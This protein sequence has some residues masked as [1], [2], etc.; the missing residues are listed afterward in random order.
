MANHEDTKDTKTKFNN[1]V[2]FN[3]SWFALLLILLIACYLRVVA[4]DT[5]PNGWRDDEVIETTV[6]AQLI[7]DGHYPLYFTQAA[8]Q[9]P[10]YHYIAALFIGA[11]GKSLFV[12]RLVS[13][14]LGLLSVAASYRLAKQFFG[15]LYALIVALLIAV[16]FWSLMWSRTKVRPIAELPL[17]LIGLSLLFKA[18]SHQPSTVSKKYI[19]LAGILLGI[20]FYTYFASLTIPVIIS[21]FAFYLFLFHRASKLW[22]TTLIVL[23]I[24]LIIYSPLGFSILNN[25]RS[26]EGMRL[27]SIADPLSAFAKG[28]A[29]YVIRNTVTTLQ[30]FITTG[31]PEWQ[32]NIAGR[33]VF[34]IIG[35][36]FFVAGIGI[37]LW[38]WRDE[39][40]AFLLIW[41]I[42]G[43][44]PAFVSVPA[45][46]LSHTITALPATYMIAN[47][48]ITFF[49]PQGIHPPALKGIP[50]FSPNDFGFR[51]LPIAKVEGL[52]GVTF[53]I[54]AI[55]L[56]SSITL[57]DIP[58]Y[59]F[60]W[61]SLPEVR[62]LYKSD[63]HEQAQKLKNAP[64]QTY[65]LNGVL[66]IWDRKAFLLEP[67]KFASP[68]RWVRK[69]WAMIFSK[70][71]AIYL[72]DIGEWKNKT[73]QHEMKVEFE[74]GLVFEGWDEIN[75][76]VVTH[77][78]VSGGYTVVE[79]PMSASPESPPFPVFIFV[80]LSQNNKMV[81]GSDRFDVDAFTLQRDDQFLQ[82]HT[83]D[84]PSGT[85]MVS[86][87]LYNPKTGARVLANGRDVI[88]IGT[89]A[90]K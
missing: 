48:P 85:Y 69:E 15:S 12:V 2:F 67:I 39:R 16:S 55:T 26:N 30:M 32:S 82:R 37:C 79:P 53:A 23:V 60:R 52:R 24:A 88:N 14:F 68:P 31:D 75:G 40:Y 61:S 33:P 36:L 8:G 81:S 44:A 6:H 20:S 34:N 49:L 51:K 56:I 27:N 62:F 19:A 89:M 7:L 11:M 63:L 87:G 73:P 4:L 43:I 66:N 17:M 54:F 74:N 42:V 57:R 83:F 25:A 29:Q 22:R 18:I 77:W 64:P 86:I 65:I 59:F 50:P 84:A 13:A 28:D 35:F 76:D 45:A 21:L 41:L 80:H 9:E 78:R 72:F 5:L 1:F 90:R 3:S 71:S 10:L 47:L 70:E 58:D 38:K 46:S